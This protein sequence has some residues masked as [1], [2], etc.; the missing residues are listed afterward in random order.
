MKPVTVADRKSGDP[1][2]H[3]E[4][5]R[6]NMI[7]RDLSI[8]LE[9]LMGSMDR[10]SES[11]FRTMFERHSAVMLL[12]D[13]IA[14]KI[15]DAN[16][17]AAEFYGYPRA[18]LRGMSV[19]RI[20]AQPES[21]VA[22]LRQ[23]AIR[24]ERTN[25]VLDHSVAD[26]T[27]RSVEV[28]ISRMDYRGRMLFFSI[29]HDI[30][31]RRQ[32]ENEIRRMAFYDPLTKLPNRRLL[33]ERL[34]QVIHADK[35]SGRHAALM[36]LDLDNF[37][38]LNDAHGHVVGDMLL[39]EVA[40]RL[41]GCVREV[42]TLAR[43]GGDEFVVVLGELTSDEEESVS[44]THGVAEKVRSRLAAP[45]VLDVGEEDGNGRT[46]EYRCTSS[47]GVVVFVDCEA[48]GET[49]LRLADAAMYKAK[50]SGGNQVRLY[51]MDA[52]GSRME[53]P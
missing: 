39:V 26:G 31:E 18:C 27:V 53:K 34:D 49:V 10:E 32:A 36:L 20:N 50:E 43:I 40:N 22:P 14:R 33:N 2:L 42:D 9:Q 16:D 41:R 5:D 37:K 8:R 1:A 23:Q 12:I 7:V 51:C 28:H 52:R 15:V 4:I 6:L 45:Y 48:G 44:Q 47:I 25:L 29:V 3:A 13:P 19:D 38:P 24:G 30:T 35:R 11:L 46:V 21:E 17:A